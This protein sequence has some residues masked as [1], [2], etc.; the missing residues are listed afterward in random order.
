MEYLPS[1]CTR[2][3]CKVQEC[4]LSTGSR[5]ALAACTQ[6]GLVSPVAGKG[7]QKRVQHI[8]LALLVDYPNKL[9]SGCVCVVGVVGWCADLF[10]CQ[11]TGHTSQHTAPHHFP[12]TRTVSWTSYSKKHLSAQQ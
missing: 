4:Q 6:Q 2:F 8:I 5:H 1:E 7:R 9:K 12:R 11:G 10:A 3:G